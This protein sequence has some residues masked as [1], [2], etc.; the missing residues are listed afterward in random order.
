M[1]CCCS[2]QPP[3][4]T[5]VGQDVLLL[6]SIAVFKYFSWTGCLVVV[7]HSRLQVLQLDRMS[8]CCSAQPPSSTSV[9]QDDL[10]LF[11]TATFKCFSWTGCLVVVQHSRLQVLQLGRMTCCCSAQPPSSTSVGQDDLLLF[12]TTAFK[13]FSW[14]GCLVVV[15]HRHLQVL[16][17][18]RMSCCCSAQPPSSPSVGQDDLL[19]FSTA[20][21][22][23]FS[24]TG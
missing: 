19:L 22:K 2:A 15:Q 6:F 23:S 9:G 16:Q 12:S 18:D 10:L 3:S 11:S 7:Q 1:S 14:T 13:Y 5:S 24:W 8:C 4:S 20:A 21:F 17:L